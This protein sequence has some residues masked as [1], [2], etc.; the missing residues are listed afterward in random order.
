MLQECYA[1][2]KD[3]DL[4]YQELLVLRCQRGDRAALE[5]LVVSWE[6]RLF[7]F[8]RRLGSEEQDAWDLL[9]QTWLKVLRGISA[10]KE[11]RNLA[12]WLYRIARNTV[13]NHGHM[14]YLH[15]ERLEE[16]PPAVEMEQDPGPR[17]LDDAEQI[18]HGL[19]QLALPHREVLTL[20]FLESMTVEQ[21]AQVL[22]VPPGTVKSRLYH[23]KRALRA[24]LA[25]EDERDLSS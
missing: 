1:V 18:H 9:Q 16:F 24:V 10:L 14:R 21:I 8:I 13:I 12:P 15:R 23:A 25:K 11:P 19:L 3:I 7:Y 17:N 22:E 2:R 4:I 5:K 6:R 20:H